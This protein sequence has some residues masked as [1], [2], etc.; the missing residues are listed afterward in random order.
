MTLTDASSKHLEQWDHFVEHS[1]NGT[2][3]HKLSFL[4]YHGSKFQDRERHL[5]VLNGNEVY[6][7]ISILL[8]A[9][10]DGAFRARSP[11]GG[12]YGGFAFRS[13][14]RYKQSREIAD[15]LIAYCRETNIREFFITQTPYIFCGESL[16]TFLFG[17]LEAG[18]HSWR[19][20]VIN[21]MMLDT[22][23]PVLQAITDSS[24]RTQVRKA[25]KNGIVI[26]YNAPLDDAYPLI[27][28]TIKKFD[29]NPTHSY[30]ELKWLHD[31]FGEHIYFT[32][33]Y[34][35]DIPIAAVTN[36]ALNQ[37]VNSSFYFS[38]NDAYLKLNA[39]RYAIASALQDAQ[40][41]GFSCYDFGTS[42]IDMKANERI[43]S[44]KEEFSR[45]GMFR[46]T[47]MWK[48]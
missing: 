19:R 35:E 5:V 27:E 24:C 41:K 48:H 15:L 1:I 14:P 8:E 29:K 31:H 17:L 32:T 13:L 39:L 26:N 28:S 38:S 43:F 36:F 9:Q 30:E 22:K 42:T 34:Y 6:A 3:F 12:S 45:T 11:Y 46:E 25:G 40:E 33:A 4:E 44:M 18:F 16:D 7:Q 23:I 20:E 47:L 37:R 2:I 10:E 21:Y